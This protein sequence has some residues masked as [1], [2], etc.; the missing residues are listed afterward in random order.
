MGKIDYEMIVRYFNGKCNEE[1]RRSIVRWANETDEHARQLFE[2][3]EL[4]FLG[5]RAD[6]MERNRVREAENRLF[7]RIEREENRMRKNVIWRG[8]MKFA[9]VV[10]VLLSL[11]GVGAWYFA[12]AFQEEWKQVATTDGEVID[13][14]L[15]DGSHVWLN[16]NSVLEYPE[17]FEK[18]IRRLR[19]SG[20]AYF[21]VTK[22]RHK[23]F[24][25]CGEAMNVQ[26]LGTKFNFKN[27]PG[28]RIVEASLLEG[29]IKAEGTHRE[30]SITLLPGQRVELNTG[31]GQMRVMDTDAVLD[32]IWH[33]DMV[34]LQNADIVKIA[35]ILGEIYD[36]KI[37]LS[38]GMEN[39]STYSGELKKKETATEMLDALKHTLHI[40]Y[41]IHN[42]VVFVSPE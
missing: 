42:G 7:E 32:A 12:G 33:S 9:A 35:E 3:E 16:E 21:E 2:W 27:A 38:P 13:V 30:G 29:E 28:C 31:T 20:E 14:V 17:K 41:K 37:I 36:V 10:A 39:L 34:H 6:E 22:N 24:V 11:S 5:K 25:V 4:Y 23:P 15:P 1:E 18:K 19:L 26:V 8:W 40:K